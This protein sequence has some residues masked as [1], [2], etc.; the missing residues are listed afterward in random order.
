MSIPSPL[1]VSEA[2]N[3]SVGYYLWTRFLIDVATG[4]FIILGVGAIVLGYVFLARRLF[5]SKPKAERERKAA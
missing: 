3:N 2:V 5:P 1:E 4:A